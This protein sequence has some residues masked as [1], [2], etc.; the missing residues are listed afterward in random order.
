MREAAILCRYG[1]QD[2]YR[3]TG[4]DPAR[5]PMTPL[6][7]GLFVRVLIELWNAEVKPGDAVGMPRGED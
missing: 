4:R 1:H 2:W 7:R 6:E 3:I 5:Q